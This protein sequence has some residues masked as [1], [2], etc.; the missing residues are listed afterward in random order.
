MAIGRS[1]KIEVDVLADSAKKLVQFNQD[2]KNNVDRL[3]DIMSTGS[4]AGLVQAGSVSPSASTSAATDTLMA[5]AQKARLG[6]GPSDWSQAHPL[7]GPPGGASR[8][9]GDISQGGEG[10]FEKDYI[11]ATK[12]IGEGVPTSFRQMLGYYGSGQLQ[13]NPLA[14]F[15]GAFDEYGVRG[16][17]GQMA[18]KWMGGQGNVELRQDMAKRANAAVFN[19]QATKALGMKLMGQYSSFWNGTTGLVNAGTST[20]AMNSRSGPLPFGLFSPAMMHGL[21]EGFWKP[22]LSSD[23]GFNGAYSLAQAQ[24]ARQAINEYGWSGG[25]M[26]DWLANT[27]KQNT[28]RTGLDA[29]TQMAVLDPMLRWGGNNFQ[30]V[31]TALGSLASAATAAGYNT[32]QFAQQLGQA[33]TQVAQQTGIPVGTVMRGMEALSSTTGLSP[34]QLAPLYTQQNMLMAAGLTHKSLGQVEFGNSQA[35]LLSRPMFMFENTLNAAARARGMS[36][37]NQ[38]HEWFYHGN[39]AQ[40]KAAQDAM[41]YGPMMLFQTDPEAFGNI[42]PMQLARMFAMGGGSMKGVM[43]QTGIQSALG[44]VQA[45]T[46]A[47]LDTK[48]EHML[49][50]YYTHNPS[51]NRTLVEQYIKQSQGQTPSERRETA[52]KLIRAYQPR[53]RRTTAKY[54]IGLTNDAK[55][56]VTLMGN[57][58][59]HTNSGGIT[60]RLSSA[61]GDFLGGLGSLASGNPVGAAEGVGK[62]VADLIP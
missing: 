15:G 46:T 11:E 52:L 12:R 30:E 43:R 29:Q 37:F 7:N 47:A 51:R 23:F 6:G 3:A 2:F 19:M 62:A 54:E 44:S 20:N 35:G 16:T 48:I 25:N 57:D 24:Q 1:N 56:L 50:G 14:P 31:N 58:P 36:G 49:S 32:Q 45:P 26:G 39:A 55:K 17:F 13:L 10:D 28:I 33:S 27:L 9:P 61:G 8:P 4:G 21:S 22:L 59:S 18:P 60:G 42:S 41:A 5:G 40:K 38:W 53:D 34:T